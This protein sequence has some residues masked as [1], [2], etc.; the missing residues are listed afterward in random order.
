M[1]VQGNTSANSSLCRFVMYYLHK[2]LRIL[3]QII[4]FRRKI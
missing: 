4:E 1:L 2:N 3:A